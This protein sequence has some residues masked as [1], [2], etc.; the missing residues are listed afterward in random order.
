VRVLTE[1]RDLDRTALADALQRHWN[2]RSAALR[3]LPVGFGSHHWEAVGEDG[4]RWF[5]SAD[6]ATE[7]VFARLAGAFRTA[8]WLRDDAGLEFVQAPVPSA[9]GAVLHR[10]DGRY[11]VRVE[12]FVDGTATE[13]GDFEDSDDRRR[14]ATLVGRV[15]AASA[16]LPD[17]LATQEDFTLPARRSLEEALAA[18]DEPWETGPFAEPARTLLRRNADDVLDRLLAYDRRAVRVRNDGSWVLTHGEPHSANV[19]REPSGGLLL[20]D[21]DTALI[22]PRERDLW[23]VLDG[24]LNGWEQY[25][26]A[27]GSVSLDEG[28]LALYREKWALTEIAEYVSEFRRPHTDT[29]DSRGGW[30]ELGEYLT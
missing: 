4:S 16:S 7:E 17:G 20:V 3:Y 23:M 19:I 5:V 9:D 2:I 13:S 30:T 27:A 26:E 28:A 25:R 1:P 12:P 10:L 6:A 11:A 14:V 8:A 15:H 24:D 29:E 21:W 22:G 18:L